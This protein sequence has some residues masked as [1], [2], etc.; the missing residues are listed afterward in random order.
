MAFSF[1]YRILMC[2]PH[3]RTHVCYYTIQLKRKRISMNNLKG[4]EG[5]SR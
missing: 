2:E 5:P 3:M 1:A 4:I